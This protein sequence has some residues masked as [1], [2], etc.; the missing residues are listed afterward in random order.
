MRKVMRKQNSA[1][2]NAWY[3]SSF[4]RFQAHVAFCLC[5][6]LPLLLFILGVLVFDKDVTCSVHF[7][8]G[9]LYT[10]RCAVFLL[11]LCRIVQNVLSPTALCFSSKSIVP[12]TLTERLCMEIVKNLFVF[13]IC[14]T[15][16]WNGGPMIAHTDR[17]QIVREWGFYKFLSLY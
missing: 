15:M 16:I 12:L 17:P 9:R 4:C 3:F 11:A 14:Y 2:A 10:T 8:G 13:F 7:T 5:L 6:V 1:G